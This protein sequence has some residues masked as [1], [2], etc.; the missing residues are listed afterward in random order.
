MTTS[1]I[2]ELIR[3]GYSRDEIQALDGAESSDVRQGDESAAA[4]FVSA[5][6]D[7]EE[8]AVDSAAAA[9]PPDIMSRSEVQSLIGDLQKSIADLTKAVQTANAKAARSP[10]PEAV[11]IEAVVSDFFGAAK[12]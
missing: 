8:A 1:E 6:A 7:P 9:A 3:A 5:A 4:D 12:K 2:L 10:A 11:S